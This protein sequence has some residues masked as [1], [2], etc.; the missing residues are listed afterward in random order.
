MTP[1]ATWFLFAA[2]LAVAVGALLLSARRPRWYA[3]LLPAVAG[4]SVG[5]IVGALAVHLVFTQ[6]A[7][8]SLEQAQDMAESP[9]VRMLIFFVWT[10]TRL[11]GPVLLPALGWLIGLVAG[12]WWG[13]RRLRAHSASTKA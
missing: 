6:M 7:G 3:R 9:P 1:F 5:A 10:A 13:G 2:W 11:L 4:A 8:L 12:L